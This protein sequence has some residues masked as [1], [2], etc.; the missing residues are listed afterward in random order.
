MAEA[1]D[2]LA[3]PVLGTRL[4]ECTGLVNA[5]QGQSVHEIFGSPDDMKFRSSM[6][7]FHAAAPEVSEFSQA[8]ATYFEGKGD[9]VTFQKLSAL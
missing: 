4:R 6:T 9:P 8:L 2:Y 7:L 5:V 3:H 1:L